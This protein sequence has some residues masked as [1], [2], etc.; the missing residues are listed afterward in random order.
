MSP[1]GHCIPELNTLTSH[2]LLPLL[3]HSLIG[4]LLSQ[5]ERSI[6]VSV[7][8]MKHVC[9]IDKRSKFKIDLLQLRCSPC[10]PL[11]S[12]S[13]YSLAG[14]PC[15]CNIVLWLSLEKFATNFLLFSHYGL[16]IRPVLVLGQVNVVR[17]PCQYGTPRVACGKATFLCRSIEA[18]PNVW[19][20][21]VIGKRQG[22]FH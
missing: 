7:L 20:K 2:A 1:F 21:L 8:Y 18:Y 16:T 5:W 10:T 3:D 15:S 11:I 6:Y 22:N 19:R 9:F 4:A 14:Q 12:Y 13:Q 17:W